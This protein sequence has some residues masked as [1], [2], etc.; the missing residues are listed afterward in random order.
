MF[1]YK[2][3]VSHLFIIIDPEKNREDGLGTDCKNVNILDSRV[4]RFI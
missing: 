4:L 1:R 2:S 3:F